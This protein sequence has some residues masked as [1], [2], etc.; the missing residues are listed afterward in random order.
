MEHWKEYRRRPLPSRAVSAVGRVLVWPFRVAAARRDLAML[1][2]MNDM[3][4][5]DIGLMRQDLRD[6]SALALGDDPTRMLSTR[7]GE[8]RRKHQR[9]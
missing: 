7:V 3:E 1:A 9:A 4:L 5:A 6:A 8:R 2:G